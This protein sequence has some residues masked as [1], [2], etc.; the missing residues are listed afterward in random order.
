MKSVLIIEDDYNI[1]KI[2]EGVI[3]NTFGENI[4]I[5]TAENGEEALNI[6]NNMPIDIFIVDIILPDCDGVELA[7]EI[8]KKYP[9]NP[10][11]IESVKGDF[12]YQNKVLQEI[13]SIAFIKKATPY[14]N[15]KIISS[16]NYAIGFVE[17][18]RVQTITF[19]QNDGLSTFILQDIMYV[20]RIKN[21]K[22]IEV[23]YYDSNIE[24]VRYEDFCGYSLS[25]VLE[26]SQKVLFQCHRG[27]LVNSSMIRKVNY[28]TIT[29]RYDNI[30]I[31]IGGKYRY[32]LISL[33]G[34]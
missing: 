8:R 16:V 22:K 13:K 14:P 12:A 34:G 20:T 19:K 9:F 7:K 25:N 21:Q 2:I 1:S 4:K 31:P 33:M 18:M 5:L 30:E 24:S 15:A 10:F 26:K 32:K 11:I 28:D 17:C 29:L 6:A 3:S 23:C 27:F